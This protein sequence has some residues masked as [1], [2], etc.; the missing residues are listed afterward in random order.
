[1][2]LGSSNELLF[3]SR[4]KKEDGRYLSTMQVLP[5]PL[6]YKGNLF[7]TMEHAYHSE[8][9][10]SKYASHPIPSRLLE[11]SKRLQIEGDIVDPKEAKKYG[12]KMS[13]KKLEVTLDVAKFNPDRVAIMTQI[14]LSRIRVDYKFA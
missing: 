3:H 11:L 5:K 12:G 4:A 8:K 14:A 7:A 10:N 9:F 13:F 1:M 6:V 2:S